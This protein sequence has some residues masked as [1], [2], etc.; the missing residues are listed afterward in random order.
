MHVRIY[1]PAQSAMQAGRGRS[2]RWVVEF[3]PQT[4]KRI[5][6]LMGWVG[7]TDTACQVC[8]LF[9]SREGAVSYAKRRGYDYSIAEP[10]ERPW[11]PKNY[12]ENFRTDRL[13]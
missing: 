9:S 12:A 10:H 11:H 2:R 4:P 3:E 5:D 13:Y 7:G 8:L 6:P 1:R